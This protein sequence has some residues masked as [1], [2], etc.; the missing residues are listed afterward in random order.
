MTKKYIVIFLI[1]TLVKPAYFLYGSKLHD[2]REENKKE[3]AE[4]IEDDNDKHAHDNHANESKNDRAIISDES[5]KFIGVDTAKAESEEIKIKLPLYGRLTLDQNKIAKV[6][7]RFPGIISQVKHNL[8]DFVKKGTVL[9][10]IE[11][12]D[13][14]R[15]YNLA[16][17][18]DGVILSR[19]TNIGDVSGAAPLFIISNLSKVWAKFHVFSKDYEKVKKGQLV[20]IKAV[21]NGKSYTGKIDMIFPT[22]DE[23]SQTYIVIAEINNP[24]GYWKP[25][26]AI[27][28]MVNIANK[29]VPVAVQKEAL[30]RMDNAEVVFVKKGNIYEARPVKIGLRDK[31]MVEILSGIDKGETYVSKGSFIIKS[32]IL[33]SEAS[34]QH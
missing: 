29:K 33:K 27:E 21:N 34:H 3:H 5:A 28:G 9:A 18:V 20:N 10:I 25:G 7:A 1:I 19:N 11:S 24:D 13:S 6:R 8:G 14:L 15:K 16:S 31:N 4:H 23:L 2:I 12:N 32:D 17:P 26:M 30:Q 22:A